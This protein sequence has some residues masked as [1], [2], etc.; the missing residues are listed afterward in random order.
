V[1]IL[2]RAGASITALVVALCV[3]ACGDEGIF[4]TTVDP[5]PDFGVADLVF[6]ENFYYCQ[7]E[8]RAILPK[9]CGPGDSAQ[10]DSSCHDTITSFRL[11]AH[12]QIACDGNVPT[13]VIPSEARGNYTSAQARMRRDPNSSPLLLRPLQKLEHPRKIFD[14]NDDAAAAI[15]EWASHVTTQ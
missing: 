4:P 8:P 15:R 2:A 6:D 11:R 12:A 7:V 1:T 9:S 10:G 13:G 14:T 3:S 5:G